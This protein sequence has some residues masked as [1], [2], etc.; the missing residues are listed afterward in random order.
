MTIAAF[1]PDRRFAMWRRL[2][3]VLVVVAACAAVTAGVC[4][5][6]EHRPSAGGSA[7]DSTVDS[8]RAHC[9]QPAP[10]C[11]LLGVDDPRGWARAF[12][13]DRADQ[14]SA[15]APVAAVAGSAP[16]Y[17]AAPRSAGRRL[18]LAL[19]VSRT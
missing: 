12:K 13:A 5:G 19:R 4:A 10:Q 1:G 7:A 2:L 16:A 3:T 15:C 17:A 9:A 8:E 6:A 14:S 11:L 18:L